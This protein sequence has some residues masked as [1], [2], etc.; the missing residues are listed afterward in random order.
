MVI[1]K[2]AP[3]YSQNFDFRPYAPFPFH[4]VLQTLALLLLLTPSR[5]PMCSYV[6]PSSNLAM[7]VDFIYLLKHLFFC[8]LCSPFL[9]LVRDGN[10]EASV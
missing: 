5:P 4:F 7:L 8:K 1:I 2:E 6:I 3:V 9:P 10:G